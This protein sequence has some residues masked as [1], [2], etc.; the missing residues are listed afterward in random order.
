MNN[1]KSSKKVEDI[2]LP[3]SD[4]FIIIPAYNE[5]KTIEKVIKKLQ[6]QGFKN[7]VIIDDGSSDN[8]YNISKSLGIYSLKHKIN[9]GQGA[10]LRTGLEF[11][12]ENNAKYIVTFDADDQH[13]EKDIK[14]L[15]IPII[16]DNYDVSLG[17]RFLKKNSAKN[18][19]FSRKLILKGGILFTRIISNIKLTDVHNG[20]RAF[21]QTSAKLMKITEKRM[22]HASEI[23]DLISKHKLKYIEIPV[24][25][26]YTDYSNEKGQSS[27][28][29]IKIAIKMVL[30]KILD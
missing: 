5:E 29:A 13:D 10:S 4:I 21:N 30:K 17:S 16:T 1:N 9:L 2:N 8:T 26:K 25:I 14:K 19:T 11:A 24:N 7:I 22:E 18:I 3:I 23:L 28:N 6:K 27:M 20:I 15:L 12:I